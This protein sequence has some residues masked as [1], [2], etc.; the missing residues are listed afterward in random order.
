MRGES[1]HSGDDDASGGVPETPSITAIPKTKPKSKVRKD[2][3][4]LEPEPTV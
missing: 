3:G 4:D 1:P 2:D